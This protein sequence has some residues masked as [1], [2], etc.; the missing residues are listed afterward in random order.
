[1]VPPSGRP[2]GG[3]RV[4]VCFPAPLAAGTQTTTFSGPGPDDPKEES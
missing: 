1:M 2:A 4:V 3:R